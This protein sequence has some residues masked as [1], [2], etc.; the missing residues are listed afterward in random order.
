[1]SKDR[2]TKVGALVV[3]PAGEVRSVGFNGF[4]RGVDDGAE[5]R[6]ERPEKY[7]WTAHAEE[8]AIAQ[9]ARSGVATAGCTLI[10]TSLHP[11][12]SCA[13]MIIQA[14]I[15]RVLAPSVTVQ[16]QR[17]WDDHEQ[18]A[19]RM[20]LEA[21]VVVERYPPAEG[22]ARPRGQKGVPPPPAPYTAEEL[23]RDNPYNQW[24]YES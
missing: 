23:E 20:F 16:A 12:C 4:A 2:S 6:H 11:C 1:M 9:A 17:I 24:M 22:R 19:M 5:E 10:V 3:G 8:N 18:R 15:T 7:F 13:R 14:G 21:G